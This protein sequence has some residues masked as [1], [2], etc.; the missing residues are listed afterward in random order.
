MKYTLL[1]SCSI[2]YPLA[3]DFNKGQFSCKP[4]ASKSEHPTGLLIFCLKPFPLA[5][6]AQSS[7]KNGRPTVQCSEPPGKNLQLMRDKS[8][9]SLS[10]RNNSEEICTWF[11]RGLSSSCLQEEAAQRCI[12][13]WLFSFLPFSL[14]LLSPSQ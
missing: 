3:S 12:L 10:L 8:S 1:V 4:T 7:Y 11:L 14:F 6:G 13:Y 9:T 5:L 2:P